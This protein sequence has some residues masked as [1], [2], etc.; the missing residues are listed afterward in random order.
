M[1]TKNYHRKKTREN[2]AN[3]KKLSA[4]YRTEANPKESFTEFKRRKGKNFLSL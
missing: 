2:Y 1:G 3:N 4:L